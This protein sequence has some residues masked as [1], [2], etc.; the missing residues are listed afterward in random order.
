MDK[1]VFD[2]AALDAAIQ[3]EAAREAEEKA[4]AAAQI[5][6]EALESAPPVLSRDEFFAFFKSCFAALDRK[7][8]DS[9]S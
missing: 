1:E 7:R 2:D 5:E 9:M 8:R 6:A 3:N 4:E